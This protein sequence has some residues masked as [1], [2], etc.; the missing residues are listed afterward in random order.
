MTETKN[1]FISYSWDNE[2]HKVWVRMLA[3]RLM[4]NGVHVH[5]DQWDVR[6]GHSLTQFMD[7]NL[8]RADF[9]LVICT[10]RYAQKSVS[11]DGGAGYEAQI[12]TAQI[13]AGRERTKFVPI[14]RTGSL[15]TGNEDCAIP[16]HFAGIFAI[17][18]RNDATLDLAFEDLL[19]HIYDEPA[20]RRPP[21][22]TRPVFAESDP[23][24]AQL[25]TRLANLEIEHWELASG[26]VR[27]ELYPDTFEIP[28]EASRRTVT[29]GDLVKLS[30]EYIYPEGAEDEE[31]LPSGERMWVQVTGTKG[32][33]YVGSLA[34]VPVCKFEWHALE[35][36]DTVIFLPEHVISIDKNGADAERSK[37]YD[38]TLEEIIEEFIKANELENID[39]DDVKL[40]LKRLEHESDRHPGKS[41]TEVWDTI[42][43]RLNLEDA[44]FSVAKALWDSVHHDDEGEVNTSS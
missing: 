28:D 44:E 19:R 22:G 3:E 20:L 8:P 10:P 34:N 42:L 7:A 9:S 29:L 41:H 31:N 33:Y 21:L 40:I 18:M 32:P 12:I 38:A 5:L 37:Q 11:R 15:N 43:E 24:A 27:N 23:S 4:A 39:V 14:I 25:P 13:A 1:V 6:P 35:F 17:D 2:P 16:P 30:F 26:V 36:G